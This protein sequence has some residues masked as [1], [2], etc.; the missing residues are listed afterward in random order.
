MKL[1]LSI[2]LI[3]FFINPIVTRHDK[4]EEA[5]YINSSDY[6]S[7]VQLRLKDLTGIVEM[8]GTL[9]RKNW[10]I[11]AAHGLN[12]V[13]ANQQIKLFD[14]A[15]TIKAITVHPEF[16]GFENDVALIQLDRPVTTAEPISLFSENTE[17]G[18]QITLVGR[19]WSG[20]GLTGPNADDK[21][22]RIATNKI[23]SV[24]NHWIKFRFDEPSNQNTTELEGISGPGDSGGPAFIEVNGQ[25]YLAGISSNQLNDQIGVKEGHYGVIEYYTR[26]SRYI[27]WIESVINGDI[28]PNETINNTFT[29]WGFPDTEIG[30]K[31]NQFM[32]AVT[33]K[34]VSDKFMEQ[35]FYKSFRESFDLK[36]FVQGISN[37]LVNPQIEEIKKAK[38]NVLIFTIISE[39]KTYLIQLEADK[40][41]NYLIGGLLFK[42]ISE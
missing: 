34:N 32:D 37:S 11:T 2:L 40:R 4:E 42:K 8:E 36:G 1:I 28:T 14:N 6:P 22:F 12:S 25:K 38:Y 20:T 30:K 15:F 16:E 33:S 19:G 39:N 18:N 27:Q 24:S 21:K 5:F 13:E 10:I 3:P 35:V 31:A 41:D 23:D 29:N 7:V 17:L 26:V 9:I